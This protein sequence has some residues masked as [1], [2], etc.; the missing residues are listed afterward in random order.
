MCLGRAV[1]V[2]T[3]KHATRLFN[4]AS[5]AAPS[6]ASYSPHSPHIPSPIC[7]PQPY[8]QILHWWPPPP[9]EFPPLF[10]FRKASSLLSLCRFHLLHHSV[11]VCL[12]RCGCLDHP[13]CL[14]VCTTARTHSEGSPHLPVVVRSSFHAKKLLYTSPVVMPDVATL[15]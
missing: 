13:G 11:L 7:K 10:Q 4:V 9:V 5:C 2:Q 8:I 3:C 14:V 1:N 15:L 12:I 6:H